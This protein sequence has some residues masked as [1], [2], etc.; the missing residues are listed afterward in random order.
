MVRPLLAALS[1]NGIRR[2][3]CSSRDV[4]DCVLSSPG[5]PHQQPMVMMV[6]RPVLDQQHQTRL[7]CSQRRQ[8]FQQLW[9]HLCHMGLNGQS[10]WPA[11]LGLSLVAYY[12][13]KNRRGNTLMSS[14]G[15]MMHAFSCNMK[16][17]NNNK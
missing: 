10:S 9:S 4:R 16:K 1:V 17:N 12:L 5:R 2:R 11:L 6:W 7:C 8:V 13:L 15:Q 14:S 3:C